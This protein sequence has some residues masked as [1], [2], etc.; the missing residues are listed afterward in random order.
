MSAIVPTRRP[1]SGSGLLRHRVFNPW[2]G[3]DS[4][5][6]DVLTSFGENWNGRNLGSM[7]LTNA[8]GA[9]DIVAGDGVY[10]V[11]VDLPG[12]SA[13]EIS[14]EWRE[15]KLL[16][17]HE[18]TEEV[19]S[20]D[21]QYLHR[22]RAVRSFRRVIALPKDADG[23]N[24]GANLVNGVLTVTVPRLA[25]KQPRKI[26]IGGSAESGEAIETTTS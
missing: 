21:E 25:E 11:S 4:L 1:G 13:E 12:L 26:T 23:A 7:S 5:F 10:T 22:E 16:L 14:L 3:V 20:K 19:E 2:H 6:D 9:V 17:S 15:G 24:I 18:A 8:L